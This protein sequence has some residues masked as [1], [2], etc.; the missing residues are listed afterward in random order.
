VVD[1][2]TMEINLVAR[3]DDHVNNT[4]RQ[5]LIYQALGYPVPAFAHLPMI[6]GAD[7]TRLSK[8]HGATNLMSYRDMGFIP[9]A[10]VNYLVRLGWSHG[11]QEIF[12]IEELVKAFDWKQVGATAGVFN[13]DKLLWVNHQWLR[14]LPDDE[15]ATRALPYFGAA[16]LPAADDQKLRLVVRQ[17]R[18]RAKTFVE[19]VQQARCFYAPIQLDEK[20]RSKHLTAE[21]R[22]LLQAVRAG[23][24][25][26]ESMELAALEKLFAEVS[27]AAGLGLGKVAQPT[28]VALTGGT[29]SP[30]IHDVVQILGKAETL[31][32]LDAALALIG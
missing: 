19:I 29:A 20:A 13:P 9:Q 2:V 1:D 26:M 21:A 25:G 7:K 32:R 5:I 11:D 17:L 14:A 24:A 23:V 10:L 31:A 30:G 16:G 27:A 22:P 8:R 4:A 18:E 15:L 28:R 12:T 3:G 6:L